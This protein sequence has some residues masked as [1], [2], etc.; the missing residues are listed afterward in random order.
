MSGKKQNCTKTAPGGVWKWKSVFWDL[1][2]WHILGM[3]HSLDVMHIT[4]NVC[5][6]L[7]ATLLNMSEKA[8]DRLKARLD[9]NF[10]RKYKHKFGKHN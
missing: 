8:K 6:S 9:H 5:K 10:S 2:Y 1:P 7:L 3:P 4:K